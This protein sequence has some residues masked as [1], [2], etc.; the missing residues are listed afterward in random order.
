MHEGD[1]LQVG[2]G[3]SGTCGDGRQ[4]LKRDCG[5]REGVA[6]TGIWQACWGRGQ[7]RGG[8]VGLWNWRG[9]GR[10]VKSTETGDV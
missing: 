1:G 6:A 7:G 10:P 9:R 2:R 3:G 8:G 4:Q 5:G